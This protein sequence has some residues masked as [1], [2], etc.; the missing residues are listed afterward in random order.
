MCSFELN[1]VVVVVD[2]IIHRRYCYYY[3]WMMIIITST[4]VYCHHLHLHLRF[5]CNYPPDRLLAPPSLLLAPG[6]F[7]CLL[8]GWLWCEA[9]LNESCLPVDQNLSRGRVVLH[10]PGGWVGEKK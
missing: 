10:L 1:I 8:S 4:F 3:Y 5:Y 9:R 6:P 7:T 2:A